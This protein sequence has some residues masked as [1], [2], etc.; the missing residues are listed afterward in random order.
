MKTLNKIFLMILISTSLIAAQGF[1][2]DK[3][4]TQTFHFQDKMGRNQAVFN[5]DAPL[6]AITGMSSKV[7][8]SV[9]F[10]INDFANTLQ[11]E[12]VIPTESIKT[13]IDLRDE[14]LRGSDWLYAEKYPR[15][16][17]KIKGVKNVKSVAG[18]MITADV[19]G[20]F[21]ARGKT[22]EIVAKSTVTYLEESKATRMRAENGGDLLGVNAEFNVSLSEL[23]IEHKALGKRVADNVDVSV[24]IFGVSNKEG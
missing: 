23:G 8:G 7:Q 18:N 2:V 16:S 5:S 6:E 14:H 4:G 21:T 20:D 10:D 13:G 9:T 11:G 1:E 19:I 17:F 24:N 3:S 15:I 12:I 22:K